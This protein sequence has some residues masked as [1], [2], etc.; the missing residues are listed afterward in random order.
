[1][2]TKSA[3]PYKRKGR[4]EGSK[5]RKNRRGEREERKCELAA[6][7]EGVLWMSTQWAMFTLPAEDSAEPLERCSSKA[8]L[9][10]GWAAGHALSEWARGAEPCTGLW[11]RWQQ[12]AGKAG[13]KVVAQAG[14]R[15]AGPKQ[16]RHRTGP[17][18]GRASQGWSSCVLG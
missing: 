17:R 16:A 13:L 2:V 14:M 3:L 7:G 11:P 9:T 8:R 12:Q 5:R 15:Q 18:G 1:M 10:Q 4:K 6:E